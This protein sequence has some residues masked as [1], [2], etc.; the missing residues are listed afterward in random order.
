MLNWRKHFENEFVKSVVTLFSGSAF[1]QVFPILLTPV[2]TRLYSSED[3]GVFFLFSSIV[4]ILSILS[5]LKYE[6]ALVLPKNDMDAVNILSSGLIIAFFVG[7]LFFFLIVL[8]KDFLFQKIQDD[9][10]GDWIFYIPVSMFFLGVYQLMNYWCNRL[11]RYRY[12]TYSKINRSLSTVTFQFSF[13]YIPAMNPGLIL[14]LLLGQFTSMVHVFIQGFKGLWIRF[15]D[16]SFSRM[17]QL[18]KKYRDIPLYNTLIS[19]T[20]TISN[21]LPI[22][23]FTRYFGLE[24]AAMYGLAIRVLG[25]PV[26]LLAQS[27]G[28]V[29]YKELSDRIHLK[30]SLTRYIYSIYKRLFQLSAIP[31]IIVGFFGPYIFNFVFGNEWHEAGR[32]A[33]I[34]SPWLIMT[35]LN[36][37]V[38]FIISILNKQRTFFLINLF[39]LT[40]R[41]LA[42]Y[43]ADFFK[44]EVMNALFFYS[45]VSILYNVFLFY[46]FIK[47]S[48]EGNIPYDKPVE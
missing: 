20:N 25:T 15:G 48:K 36:I 42:I 47:I 3:F 6:L 10:L 44:L 21:H 14:G 31:F 5:T 16:V 37:P 4:L 2:L 28:Q 43:A 26:N 12:I 33:R 19:L 32:F 1:A 29:F 41:F 11:K 23:L 45:A 18:L 40:G 24:A 46:Y 8:L 38:S 13:G 34:M 39:L 22:L 30:E 27:V 7:M 17:I 35:F 9:R